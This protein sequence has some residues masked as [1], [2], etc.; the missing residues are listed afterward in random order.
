MTKGCPQSWQTVVLD[1]RT[2]RFWLLW[3]SASSVLRETSLDDFYQ[4][5]ATHTTVH[6]H[7]DK[8]KVVHSH[9]HRHTL[10]TLWGLEIFFKSYFSESPWSSKIKT[11]TTTTAKLTLTPWLEA[12]T[13]L[14][15]F[16]H[17]NPL[18]SIKHWSQS[19]SS[20]TKPDRKE[21]P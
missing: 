14:S 17:L 15:N 10:L 13:N 16:N 5:P 2:L 1:H 12:S 20:S 11:T 21:S 19:P 18:T 4:L 6:E 9:A 8:E 3:L 7:T